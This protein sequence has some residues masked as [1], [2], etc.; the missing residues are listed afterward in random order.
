[1]TYIVTHYPEPAEAGQVYQIKP[2]DQAHFLAT[3]NRALCFVNGN[4]DAKVRNV[5]VYLRDRTPQKV[6]AGG[7]V[8]DEGGWLEHAI[9][10]NYGGP[11]NRR[12]CIGAIQRKVGAE[13]EFHS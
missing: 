9:I 3:M 6:A 1:M 11:G 2:D 13:S 5:E 7:Q 8:Y 10:V 4:S 12:L